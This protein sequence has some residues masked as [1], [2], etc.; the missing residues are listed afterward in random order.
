MLESP[1]WRLSVARLASADIVLQLLSH[2]PVDAV[3]CVPA[4]IPGDAPLEIRFI[5]GGRPS[6]FELCFNFPPRLSGVPA[7]CCGA[8]PVRRLIDIIRGV[9][10]DIRSGAKV[11]PPVRIVTVGTPK[12]C[13]DVA[14]PVLCARCHQTPR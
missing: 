14:T 12:L 11:R 7:A 13:G 9:R 10:I 6:R 8:V 1:L 5:T 4:G 2:E 3:P